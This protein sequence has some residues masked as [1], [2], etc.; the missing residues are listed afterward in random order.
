[1]S[2]QV[3]AR[4]CTKN[5]PITRIGWPAAALFLMSTCIGSARSETVQQFWNTSTQV[6]TGVFL[7]PTGSKHWGANQTAN[8]PD[9]SVSADERLKLT[10][11]PAGRLDVRLI[12]KSGRTCIVKGVEVT[13]GRRYAFSIGDDELAHCRGPANHAK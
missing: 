8:D 1:M 5:H 4:E 6:F 10:N 2:V 13:T 12:D 7:A 11:V 3:S 9:G